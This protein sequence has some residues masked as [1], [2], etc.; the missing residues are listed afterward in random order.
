MHLPRSAD[1]LRD[2][3]ASDMDRGQG[4][5][6]GITNTVGRVPL[7]I[8]LLVPFRDEPARIAVRVWV[9]PVPHVRLLRHRVLDVSAI[10]V[11][12]DPDASLRVVGP[13]A[14]ERVGAVAYSVRLSARDERSATYHRRWKSA[15]GERRRE[16]ASW[17]RRLK[18]RRDGRAARTDRIVATNDPAMTFAVPNRQVRLRRVRRIVRDTADFDIVDLPSR[19]RGE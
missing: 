2:C 12:R 3:A 10:G 19:I 15:Y 4:V 6:S 7:S 11:R 16:R 9:V 14:L 17:R 13:R 18:R 5:V 8:V 1:G